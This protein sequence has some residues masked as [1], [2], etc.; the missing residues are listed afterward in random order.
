M[1]G[2][3]QCMNKS[4]AAVYRRTKYQFLTRVA[5]NRVRLG[6]LLVVRVSYLPA[7]QQIIRVSAAVLTTA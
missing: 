4:P 1:F 2:N 3:K 5:V 6:L 7:L